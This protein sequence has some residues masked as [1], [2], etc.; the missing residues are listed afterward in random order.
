MAP[1]TT[2][3]IVR[4]LKNVIEDRR[5]KEEAAELK[6]LENKVSQ[7]E[8]E[9]ERL[10]VVNAELVKKNE[11]NAKGLYSYRTEI[12]ELRKRKMRDTQ[13]LTKLMREI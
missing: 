10:K 4:K 8:Q 13:E 1:T 11:M 5:I 3:N 9:N 2:E 6:R 12:Y 7:L